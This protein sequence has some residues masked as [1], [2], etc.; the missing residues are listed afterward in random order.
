MEDVDRDR[1]SRGHT[2]M[3]AQAGEKPAHVVKV[4]E[5]QMSAD[6]QAAAV[7]VSF[8]IVAEHCQGILSQPKILKG[9]PR[10][11]LVRDQEAPSRRSW[12]QS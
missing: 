10:H 9:T 5:S 12:S 3:S 2:K 11:W 4:I 6:R 1:T 8:S 7:E